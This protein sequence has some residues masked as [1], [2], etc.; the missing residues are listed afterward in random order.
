MT[1][2]GR[3]MQRSD[4]FGVRIRTWSCPVPWHR[5]VKWHG[6]Q[7]YCIEDGCGHSNVEPP[8][9]PAEGV[10]LTP[11]SVVTIHLPGES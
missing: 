3:S 2:P 6:E 4:D 10:T 7:A 5:Y 9:V 8:P 11:H 1:E